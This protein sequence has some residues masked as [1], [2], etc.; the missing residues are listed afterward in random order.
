[1]KSA[2]C[3]F[4]FQ[5]YMVVLLIFLASFSN[6]ESKPQP[7]LPSQAFLRVF[8]KGFNNSGAI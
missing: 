4:S 7:K 1:M 2:K 3:W 8:F 5:G 6:M